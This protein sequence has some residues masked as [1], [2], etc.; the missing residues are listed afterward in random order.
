[1]F[2]SSMSYDPVYS[3]TRDA[4]C[5]PKGSG[6]FSR[7]ASSDNLSNLGFCN[8]RLRMGLPLHQRRMLKP[9]LGPS[10]LHICSVG[11][12]DDMLH[13]DT[14]AGR[15]V[16]NVY[17]LFGP[18]PRSEEERKAMG[19]DGPCPV[20]QLPITSRNPASGPN[21]TIAA[22]IETRPEPVDSGGGVVES[23]RS[24]CSTRRY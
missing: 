10:I 7:C 9:S 14:T 3:R 17:C 2:P 16:A 19:V 6:A 18:V 23:H 21:P 11:S 8:F 5:P 24:Y 12:V 20:P 15:V 22:T 1:M 13:V 4:K